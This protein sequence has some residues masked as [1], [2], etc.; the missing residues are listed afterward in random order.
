[1]FDARGELLLGDGDLR[2]R[3]FARAR[4]RAQYRAAPSETHQPR[5]G[6]RDLF[7]AYVAT[8]S[9]SFPRT[10]PLSLSSCARFTSRRGIASAISTRTSPLATRSA[11][12]ASC[13]D[14]GLIT[15]NS[16]RSPRSRAASSG[17][18]FAIVTSIP[19]SRTAG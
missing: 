2:G 4:G 8:V 7:A 17:G 6:T 18:T 15:S 13:S 10:W 19:P 1:R 11:I 3:L 14:L 9:T 5:G 16:A 12:R